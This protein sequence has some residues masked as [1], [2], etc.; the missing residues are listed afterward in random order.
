MVFLLAT[1]RSKLK[2]KCIASPRSPA[3]ATPEQAGLSGASD[4][5]KHWLPAF[6]EGALALSQRADA[7]RALPVGH[8]ANLSL[9]QLAMPVAEHG[10]HGDVVVYM[11]WK[12][13]MVSQ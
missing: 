10:V 3:P 9:V 6:T 11:Y 5:L 1:S 7:V 12:D 4:V 2:Q 8:L 13:L